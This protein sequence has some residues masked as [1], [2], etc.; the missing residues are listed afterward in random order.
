MLRLTLD[1][2][3]ELVLMHAETVLVQILLRGEEARLRTEAAPP[4]VHRLRPPVGI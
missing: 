4:L 1:A 3:E 2:V